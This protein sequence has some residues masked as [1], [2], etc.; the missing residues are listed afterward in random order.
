MH[1]LLQNRDLKSSSHEPHNKRDYDHL[2]T[3]CTYIGF[4]SNKNHFV[5]LRLIIP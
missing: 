4:R 1:K 5:S 3:L 2:Q